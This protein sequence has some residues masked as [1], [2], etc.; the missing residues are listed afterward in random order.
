MTRVF[1]MR[2]KFGLIIHW[3]GFLLGTVFSGGALIF[4]NGFATNTFLGFLVI[5]LFFTPF[6]LCWT[7]RRSLTGFAG[8]FPWKRKPD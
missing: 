4:L 3:I 8:F 6:G 5:V 7:I 2:E 1:I